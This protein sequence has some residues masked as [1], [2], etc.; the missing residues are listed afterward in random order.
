MSTKSIEHHLTSR[1]FTITRI[2]DERSKDLA[3]DALALLL[4]FQF[5]T[6]QHLLRH[7][8]GDMR[9]N[10]GFYLLL[11]GLS[12]NEVVMVKNLCHILQR[13]GL[14]ENY[15]FDRA[16]NTIRGAVA[17]S[18]RALDFLGGRWLESCIR[19]HIESFL[20]LDPQQIEFALNVHVVRPP[21][22]D[23]KN[24][25]FEMDALLAVDGS[26]YWWEAKCGQYTAEHTTRYAAVAKELD[27]PHSQCFLVLG[28]PPV[29]EEVGQ[30]G[31]RIGFQ[32]IQPQDIPIRVEEIEAQHRS[33]SVK[34]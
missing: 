30:L 8:R 15:Y 16:A 22:G 14:L 13:N 18:D 24:H 6:F 7:M 27:L 4:S 34:G 10:P 3:L 11:G 21:Q 31:Q 17:T 33:S 23:G 19:I 5:P 28:Q 32:I 9:N 2:G 12:A 1:G 29:G 26:L 25:Q 20:N